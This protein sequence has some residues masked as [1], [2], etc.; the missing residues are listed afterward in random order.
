MRDVVVVGAGLAGLTA[1]IRLA[2]AGRSVTLLTKGAGGLQLSQG[3]VDILGYDPDRVERPL[4]AVAR[5]AA[6]GGEHP[7][8]ILGPDAV[9]EAVCFLAEVVGA[10]LLVGDPEVNFQLPTAVGAVRPTALAG[11]SMVAGEVVA[12][13]SFV[14]VGFRR[15][16]DFRPTLVA[17]N[18]A[19]TEAPSGGAVSARAA[20]VDVPAR[21]DE[22]DSTGLTFARALDL[23]DVRRAL[24]D[25]VA[26]EAT[27]DE[28]VG[29]P[30]VLGFAPD[31]WREIQDRV[32][33]PIFEIPLQPPSIPGMRLN[34]RLSALAQQAGVRM[35]P[36]SKV[37][38]HTSS[39]GALTSMTIGSAGSPR[40][41]QARHFVFAPGG[42]ESGALSVDSHGRIT[43]PTLQLPLTADQAFPLINGDYWGDQPL[44]RVGVKVDERMRVVDAQGVPVYPNL[45]AAGGILAGATRWEDKS[46]DGIAAASAVRAADA[47]LGEAK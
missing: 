38:A 22:V 4:D 32:G 28:I 19:R 27:G 35:V 12:G 9:R 40:E 1:A 11:P 18:L 43:E 13:K 16:K 46:G 17:G 44:F 3:T 24:A 2:R 31:A 33:R 34:R 10:D 45:Y 39:D 23:P 6:A 26:R 21:V 7:Y 47:I 5:M 41:Y 29:L 37:V 8:C 20:W 42:F 15:L 25:A 36:G 30:A 14:I